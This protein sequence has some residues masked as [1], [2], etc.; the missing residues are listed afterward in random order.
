[1][2]KPIDEIGED[3]SFRPDHFQAEPWY[4]G[5]STI[6]KLLLTERVVHIYNCSCANTPLYNYLHVLVA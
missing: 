3:V 4:K 1:M 6:Q 2:A 5:Y